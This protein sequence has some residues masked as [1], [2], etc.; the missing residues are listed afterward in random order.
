MKFIFVN[1]PWQALDYPS[2][3]CGVLVS[4]INK[5]RPH[6]EVTEYYGNLRWAE[7]LLNQT[8]EKI[9]P[10]Q[11]N[12]ISDNTF[13]YGAGE[14]I[15]TN[16]FKQ[17]DTKKEYIDFLEK[18]SVDNDM[19]ELI[20]NMYDLA[21]NFIEISANEILESNPD[22]VGF[23][24]TFMQNVPS[25][26]VAKKIKELSPSTIIVFG[27]GNCDSEQGEALHRNFEFVD[28]VVRGE[29]E[30]SLIQL[31]DALEG[32][33]NF[34]KVNGL[35]WRKK[36]KQIV[37]PQLKSPLP[38]SEIPE[39]VY[40]SYFNH[41]EM[42]PLYGYVQPK[43]TFESSRGCWWGEKHQCL[44]CGLN[45]SLMAYRSKR[46]YKLWKT[47]DTYVKKY[48]VLDI[49]MVD[50]ILNMNY[51]KT[52]LPLIEKSR[53]D[54]RFHYEIKSNLNNNQVKQLKKSNVRHVQPGIESLN[55]RALSIMKK[56]VR[57][58]QNIKIL[59][60][61]E[62]E[63]IEVSWNYLY[64]FPGESHSDYGEVIN[65]LSLLY[66]LSPPTGATRIAAERFSP[67]FEN[68]ELGLEITGPAA[69]YYY[70]YDLPK[71]EL[72]DLVFLFESTK[73][74]ISDKLADVMQLEIEKWQDA[75]SS[76]TLSYMIRDDGTLTISDRR[77]YWPE[78]DFEIK[79][80]LKIQMYLELQ[81]GLTFEG[82]CRKLQKQFPNLLVEEVKKNLDEFR[83]KGL[84][85]LES[86][87]YLSL[88]IRENPQRIRI[89]GV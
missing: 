78:N 39:P 80:P 59:E 54:I 53:Y 57:G 41:M 34:E 24:T 18:R 45:G 6:H 46:P 28:F 4:Q 20:Q 79:D 48:K 9:T 83:N 85:F 51:F 38:I 36:N 68:P 14:W 82:L 22:V 27:G 67:Y 42:S 7:F 73:A 16:S 89:G 30:K 69:F 12:L 64:G 3:A 65:Q 60:W 58:I 2:L 32:E 19:L 31:I 43:L 77:K 29:G 21:P 88:A 33:F 56:G 71:T 62:E 86:G 5:N 11:Y 25:L 49:I 37:N 70:V 50:N 47:I 87:H 74:G 44:F 1:M 63:N 26:A 75:Y 10:H 76:S 61:C 17:V 35:C 15:F 8:D 55:S 23:S 13:F 81:K 52:F 40:D 84:V 72:K 66:H